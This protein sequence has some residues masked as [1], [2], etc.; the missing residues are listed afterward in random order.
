MEQVKLRVLADPV[1]NKVSEIHP[2]KNGFNLYAKIISKNV[3]IDLK[4]IDGSR[5]V[6]CDFLVGDE[7]GTIKMRLRNENFVDSL[8]EG[9]E[10]IIRNCKVPIVKSHIRIQVDAFGKIEESNEGIIKEVNTQ[11]NFSNDVYEHSNPKGGKGRYNPGNKK[12]NKEDLRDIK[13]PNA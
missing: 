12:Y 5:V 10:I 2:G 3:L 6:I 11:K 7:T 9:K 4:R 8:T 1:Y 13:P